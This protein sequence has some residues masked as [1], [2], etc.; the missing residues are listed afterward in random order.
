MVD[1]ALEIQKTVTSPEEAIIEASLIRLRPIMM[2]T[3]AAI[4]GALPL[5]FGIG[6]SAEMLRGLGLVIVGGLLFSQ[7]LTLYVT[8]VLYVSL[9]KG[10]SFPKKTCGE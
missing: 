5:A 10:K 1:Y 4:I 9:S 7:V 2:T 6:E 3:V 8:P